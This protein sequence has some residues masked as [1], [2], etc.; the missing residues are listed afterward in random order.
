MS[1]DN[2]RAL[3][4]QAA[5]EVYKQMPVEPDNSP[6]TQYIQQLGQK[7]LADVIWQAS[8]LFFQSGLAKANLL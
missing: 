7:L 1:R 5:A 3:G 4:L 2:Q 6:E 8:G